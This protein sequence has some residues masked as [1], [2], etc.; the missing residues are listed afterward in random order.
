[1]TNPGPSMGW[2]TRRDRANARNAPDNDRAA[3]RE[4]RQAM[5]AEQAARDA[6][7]AVEA[8]NMQARARCSCPVC[9]SAPVAVELA[10]RVITAMQRLPAHIV[11]DPDV[12]AALNAVVAGR[13]IPRASIYSDAHKG[14]HVPHRTYAVADATP[15]ETRPEAQAETA[16]KAKRR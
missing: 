13:E 3:I 14:M 9:D 6:A 4:A 10:A 2:K 16:P 5:Y 7:A 11:N 1:M 8:A 15:A 12:V